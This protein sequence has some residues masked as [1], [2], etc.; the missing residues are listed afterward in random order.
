MRKNRFLLL[1]LVILS[2]SLPVLAQAYT[3]TDSPVDGIGSANGF[4]TYGIN[5]YNY[6]PGVQSG[7]I[8]I[9]IFTD[10]PEAGITVG[11]WATRPAD[12]F[13]TE[14]YYGTDYLWAIPLVN[15]ETFT[16]GVMY[17]VDTFYTSDD[18]APSSGYI[19]TPGA[20][21]SIATVGENYNWTDF[22]AY[23]GSVTWSQIGSSPDYLVHIEFDSRLY[24]DD[25]NATWDLYWGTA[26]CG[27][28]PIQGGVAPVP[29][30]AT[31]VLLGSGL[32]GL[33]LLKRHKK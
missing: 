3:I 7:T 8:S 13:I 32:V 23:P 28:D 29:E 2:I 15:H 9:D 26:T 22:S 5:V 4:E 27:N 6:T 16:A 17:A 11:T 18:F 25:P 33:A 24:Q 21:V 20:P 14:N 1:A 10:Y 12:L 31:M 19:Y 30:P